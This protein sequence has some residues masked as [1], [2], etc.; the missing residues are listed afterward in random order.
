MLAAAL[1]G[2]D[3]LV[4]AGV[5]GG[6]LA[7][8]LAVA[9]KAGGTLEDYFVSG[10]SLPWWLAGSSIV[11]TTFACDTPLLVTELVRTQGISANWF[12]WCFAGAHVM[13]IVLMARLWRRSRL[14]TDVSLIELRYDGPAATALQVFRALY[15]G[16]ALNMLI[17]GWVTQAMLKILTA[18]LGVSLT[19]PEA[20]LTLGPIALTGPAAHATVVAALM[21][22]AC[23][24]SLFSG[25]WGVVVADLLQLAVA[26]VGAVV[27]AVYAVGQAGGLSAMLARPEMTPERLAVLPDL[28]AGGETLWAFVAYVGLQWYT[29]KT[30]DSGGYIA[31]RLMAAKNERHGMLAMLWFV[32]AH[33]VLRPWPWIMV[34]LASLVLL[35]GNE[36]GLAY[37]QMIMLCLP[38][39]LRGLLVASLLAAFISTINTQLNWGASYVTR[40]VVVRLTGAAEDD[41]RLVWVGRGA[42]LAL[43]AL[44]AVSSYF[45]ESIAEAYKFFVLLGAGS[46][47]VLVGRWLW[48]R[49]NA[50]SE[51]VVLAVALVCGIALR[52]VL[53]MVNGW[54]GWRWALW[55]DRPREVFPLPFAI[56]MPLVVLITTVCW[57]V[58]TLVTRSTPRAKLR[59][60]YLRTRPPGPGWRTIAAECGLSVRSGVLAWAL[61]AW[62]LGVTMVFA[63][64]VGLGQL[65]LGSRWLGAGLLLA[66]AA[67]GVAFYLVN[68]AVGRRMEIER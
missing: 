47:L 11:A 9:K 43:M 40:D 57:I 3:W 18:T 8:A 56:E 52:V 50:Y 5:L 38:A 42:S 41:K 46:G 19:G 27:L 49:I 32:I 14:V 16:V 26:L 33:Y 28:A 30:A 63:G 4:I 7:A 62:A 1:T 61:L 24:Y 12:W 34:A 6:T 22:L 31:Q 44:A 2:W 17:I 51:I 39:G 54:F 15:F 10:R 60:F 36:H 29:Q 66:G 53:P 68:E 65:L 35:P 59:E 48:W 25:L 64:L 23:L 37:P 67:A 20:A 55:S 13:G 21:L 58:A 45:I